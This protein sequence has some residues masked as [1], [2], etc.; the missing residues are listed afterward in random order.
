M[1]AC[2]EIE[3]SPLACRNTTTPTNEFAVSNATHPHMKTSVIPATEVVGLNSDT[4]ST[5][6]QSTSGGDMDEVYSSFSSS[7]S[8][9]SDVE[10]IDIKAWSA[11]GTRCRDVIAN[12]DDIEDWG[13]DSFTFEPQPE[14]QDFEEPVPVDVEKWRN[15]GAGVA[16]CLRALA[17]EE[18]SDED[19]ESPAID[20]EK[21]RRVG[22]GVAH[23][24]RAAVAEAMEEEPEEEESPAT[25]KAWQSVG[26]HCASVFRSAAEEPC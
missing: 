25:I 20:V 3:S 22:Q 19:E 5:D 4:D 9:E 8:A 26:C 10:D 2:I 1:A 21:W 11:L 13:H 16:L 23:C 14:P 7:G 24:L 18:E 15:V 12:I 17:D 6:A